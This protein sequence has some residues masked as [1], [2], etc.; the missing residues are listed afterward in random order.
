MTALW[1]ASMISPLDDFDGAPILRRDLDLDVGHG[2]IASALLHVSSLGIFEASLNGEP[3]DDDVLSPG[4]SS[5]EWRLRYRSYDVT[6][7]VRPHTVVE[8]ALGNGW[9]RGR[10]GWTGKSAIYGDRLGLIAQLEVTFADGHRQLVVTDER[11]TACPS[12]TIANDLYDGQ[13][14]DARRWDDNGDEVGVEV[15]EFDT[16]RLTPYVGPPVR[17]QETIRPVRIW[18]SPSGRTLID[19]GQNLVGWIRSACS[20]DR[21]HDDHGATCGGPRARRARCPPA[22]YREGDR[23]VH[24]QRRRRRLRADDDVPRLSLR[25]GRRLSGGARPQ[26]ALE[27]IVVHSDLERIG[28][29]ACSDDLLNQ[30]HANV[31]WGLRGNFVDVPTDCPQRDERLGWTGDLAVFAPTAAFLYDVQSFLQDWLLDLAVEQTAQDGRVPFVVPDVIKYINPEDNGFA[32]ASTAIWGDVAVWAPWALWEAYG[33]R[34]VLDASYASLSAHV[35]R[36]ASLVSPTGLWDRGF[37]FGDWLD[38][39]SPPDRP[40]AANADRGVVATACLYRSAATVAATAWII[41][42]DDD[43]AAFEALAART[44]RAFNEHY[45]AGDGTIKSDAVTVYALAIVFGLLDLESAH[46]G[47]GAVGGT[48]R[49]QRV[50]HRDRLR[51]H[52]VRH[53]RSDSHRPRRRRVRTSV[54]AELPVVAVHRGDGSDDDLGAL[55]LDAPGRNRSTQVR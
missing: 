37:Q 54:A 51:R 42:R 17:R 9:Y 25:R 4:W 47:R 3:V 40:W 11:W 15:M 14:I 32:D 55:G 38:P 43:A 39:D 22:A 34:A 49:G 36:V 30:L 29:F 46:R 44:R 13:T 1:S 27:A 5:Y 50:P 33:D 7:L 24:P 28:H 19:F 53:R 8:V 41:G 12:A 6:A 45:V 16:A 21:G 52:P 18:T 35:R 20:V 10:L 23:S 31:V 48:G 2:D 26:T